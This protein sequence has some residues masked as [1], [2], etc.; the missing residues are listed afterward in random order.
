MPNTIRQW[1]YGFLAT[2]IGGAATAL[3]AALA[4]PSTFDPFT[5]LG[6]KN[7]ARIA[8]VPALLHGALYLSKSPVPGLVVTDETKDIQP[9]GVGLHVETTTVTK[10]S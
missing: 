4:M 1:L 10:E 6:W 2:V 9:S 3:S 5:P 7:M 8:I